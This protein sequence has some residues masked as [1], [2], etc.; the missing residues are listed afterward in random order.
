MIQKTR[1]HRKI[2]GSARSQSI[3]GLPLITYGWMDKTDKRV[4]YSS[5]GFQID[6]DKNIDMEFFVSKL[7]INI[8]NQIKLLIKNMLPNVRFQ[9]ID[10]DIPRFIF[11]TFKGFIGVDVHIHSSDVIPTDLI[12]KFNCEIVNIMFNNKQFTIK[13]K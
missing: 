12:E 1:L 9:I 5:L 11:R 3:E 8:N 10:I 7:E 4:F 2:I 13:T 6:I